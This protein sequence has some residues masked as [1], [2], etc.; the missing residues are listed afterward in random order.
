MLKKI[1]D[2]YIRYFLKDNNILKK[3]ENNILKK[4]KKNKKFCPYLNCDG[5]GEIIN[6]NNPN[7]QFIKCSKGHEFCFVCLKNGIKGKK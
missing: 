6:L 1:K 4:I 3:F 5:I 7:N 2:E